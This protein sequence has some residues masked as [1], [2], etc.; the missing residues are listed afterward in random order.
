M[1]LNNLEIHNILSI[2]H[3]NVSFGD[4]GLV[5]VEGF[6]FDTNRANGAG[7]SA[8]FNSI[9]Y[10]LYDKIPRK[11]TKSEILRNGTKAGF[12]ML[13]LTTDAGENL[14]V[15][16]S[17]PSGLEFF[18]DGVKIEMT[19][20]EFELKLG[21]G[22]TQFLST[23]Y[24][25]QDSGDR[26]ISLDDRDKK[27]F[28]LKI[29]NL[30]S[31]DTHKNSLSVEIKAIAQKKDLLRTKLD[32]YKNTILAYK[33]QVVSV[34]DIE[35]KIGVLESEVCSLNANIKNFE[36]VQEPDTSKYS[37]VETQIEEK[38]VNFV[39]IRFQA[40]AKRTEL[41]TL[42]NMKAQAHCP[43]CAT[44]LKV[45]GGQ[46]V[47]VSDETAVQ[48]KITT[49]VSEIKKLEDD[50]LKEVEV[51]ELQKRI[52][53]K[54]NEEYQDFNNAKLSATASLGLVMNKTKEIT[55][56]KEQIAR[57]EI[58]KTKAQEIIDHA[59]IA[60]NEIL[61]LTGEE[62]LLKTVAAFF[63]PTGAPAYIMDTII[64]SFNDAVSDYVAAIWPNATYSLQSYKE[65]KDKTISTK[66]S[67]VLTLGG[68]QMSVGALSGGEF[69]ALSL[70]TDFAIVDVLATKFGINMSPIVLDEPFNG[71]D[72]S[73]K[74]LV[75][76]LLDQISAKRQV[77]VVDHSS[78]SKALF[79]RTVRVEKKNG[80]SDI[81]DV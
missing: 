25:A 73:G 39:K 32:G 30:E 20:E 22:Y 52:R 27:E 12:A 67:E 78:E 34:S 4:T 69:R 56:L 21:V 68:I 63:D 41:T 33:Q 2:E 8:I 35:T 29:M 6:D 58:I 53:T 44:G 71:L 31:F 9:S 7:K 62:D 70:A 24:N 38:L 48:E 49:L 57:N 5:L 17:R 60:Q 55:N 14:S 64:D 19:Q 77:W 76:D 23:M 26:F 79:S 46:L 72:T 59:T 11:I 45:I 13:T 40:D 50:L 10:A 81:K 18:R 43:E 3:A 42:K 36:S 16:R 1:K 61:A 65:N 80:I 74:E 75:I 54:K 51:K 66:F 15:K 37:T 47:K 28:M